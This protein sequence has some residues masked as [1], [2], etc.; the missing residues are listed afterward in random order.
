MVPPFQQVLH[1]GGVVSLSVFFF[2]E[3][4]LLLT[5]NKKRRWKNPHHVL[6]ILFRLER[7]VPDHTY[8]KHQSRL[9]PAFVRDWRSGKTSC[10]YCS[11]DIACF[12]VNFT[13]DN[14]DNEDDDNGNNVTVG[15]EAASLTTF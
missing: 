5:C 9:L 13:D 8:V 2:Y 4:L 3:R 1:T 7:N 6:D 10:V 15:R 14:D 12:P 11:R